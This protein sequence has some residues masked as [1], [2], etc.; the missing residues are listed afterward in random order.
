MIIDLTTLK[1]QSL[2]FEH[3]LALEEIDLEGE[4]VKLK[5]AVRVS[6]NV[7]KRAAQ[8]EVAGRIFAD[9]L[10]ECSRCLQEAEKPLEIEFDT[11]FVTPEFFPEGKET[12]LQ[13]EDLE[14]DIFAGDAIDL[15][16]LVRE[17]ILLNLPT[18]VFCQEECKG[19]CDKCGANLNLIDCN[20]EENEVDPRWAALKNLK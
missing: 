5:S 2:S 19:F 20:C 10:L 12:E 11:V 6:G 7:T 18:Q 4:A 17:Q 1:S 3:S 8:T 16:E 14:V 9:V 15:T 13:Q